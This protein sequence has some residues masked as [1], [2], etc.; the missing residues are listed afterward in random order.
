MN[1]VVFIKN[2]LVKYEDYKEIL[3]QL[4]DKVKEC[5]LK[6]KEIKKLKDDKKKVLELIENDYFEDGSFENGYEVLKILKGEDKDE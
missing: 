3:D 6:D 1:K 2:G 4:E 5:K